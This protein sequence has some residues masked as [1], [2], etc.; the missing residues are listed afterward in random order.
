MGASWA[1]AT[2]EDDVDREVDWKWARVCGWSGAGFMNSER[3]LM[4]AREGCRSTVKASAAFPS[5]LGTPG[6]SDSPENSHLTRARCLYL[7]QH[8]SGHKGLT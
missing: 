7:Q 2:E 8:L 1:A 4:V 5:P 3:R 6:W